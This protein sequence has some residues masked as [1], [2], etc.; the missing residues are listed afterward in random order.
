MTFATVFISGPNTYGVL[1]ID[2][3]YQPC[4]DG[5]PLLKG[6]KPLYAGGNPKEA[7][8]ALVEHMLK[9]GQEPEWRRSPRNRLEHDWYDLPMERLTGIISAAK[10]TQ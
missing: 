6:K 2:G 8:K 4:K 3:Q 9:A 5:Q 7:F 1:L 10:A